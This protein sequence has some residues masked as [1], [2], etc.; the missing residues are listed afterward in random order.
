[1]LLNQQEIVENKQ[2][3]A[4]KPASLTESKKVCIFIGSSPLRNLSFLNFFNLELRIC[5]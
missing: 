3:N 4:K 2:N 5:I 1:M